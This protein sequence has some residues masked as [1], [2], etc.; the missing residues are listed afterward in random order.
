M[1]SL[2]EGTL[3]QFDVAS[4]FVLRPDE[5]G[6]IRPNHDGFLWLIACIY[7]YWRSFFLVLS[8]FSL[9]LVV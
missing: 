9:C 5:Q 1:N 2:N 4:A 7:H 3:G 8:L 6:R